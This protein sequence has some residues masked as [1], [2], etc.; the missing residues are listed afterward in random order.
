MDIVSSPLHFVQVDA[1][2]ALI[3]SRVY[4][5]E[6]IEVDH[7]DW[8]RDTL[9]THQEIIEEFFGLLRFETGAVKT[10]SS[11]GSKNVRFAL[12]TEPQVNFALTLSRN[13]AKTMRKKA[14]LIADFERAKA[15]L[16]SH[17]EAQFNRPTTQSP[18]GYCH[19]FWK[20]WADSGI[21]DPWYVRRVIVANH[22]YRIVNKLVCVSH[23]VYTELVL[24]FRSQA[25]AD[26]SEL[27]VELQPLFKEF[28]EKRK[29]TR[30]AQLR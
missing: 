12:L 8:F 29:N 10:E 5:R 11:R 27:P 14:E 17:F 19:T 18:A 21:K 3:D 7:S 15:T 9:L 24:T 1:G 25:G 26:I 13:T 30:A 4:C 22:D 6:V 2:V 23:G 16:R 28:E 20:V